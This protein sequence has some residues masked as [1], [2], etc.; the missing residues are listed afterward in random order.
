ML[1]RKFRIQKYISILKNKKK[2]KQQAI[3]NHELLKNKLVE[4]EIVKKE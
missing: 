2:Y 4:E 3:K 1:K